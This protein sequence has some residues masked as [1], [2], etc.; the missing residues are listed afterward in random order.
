MGCNKYLNLNIHNLKN[1]HKYNV[2]FLK[3]SINNLTDKLNNKSLNFIDQNAASNL[4]FNNHIQQNSNQMQNNNINNQNAGSNLNFN[5]QIQQNS[6]QMQ[7][8]NFNNHNNQSDFN[9]IT[10]NHDNENY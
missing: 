6:N 4:N 2:E 9:N 10:N 8:S 3:M 1:D 5:N 7:N